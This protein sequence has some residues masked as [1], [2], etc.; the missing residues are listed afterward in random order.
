MG[1]LDPTI[2]HTLRR[3]PTFHLLYDDFRLVMII[4]DN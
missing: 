3:Q 4:V 1:G 2:L